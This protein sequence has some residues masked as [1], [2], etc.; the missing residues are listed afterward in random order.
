MTRKKILVPGHPLAPPS[1]L[2]LVSR[3]NLYAKIGGGIHECHWCK[4]KLQWGH[5]SAG[6]PATNCIVVDHL[7]NDVNNDAPENLVPACNGCNISRG[8]SPM[9]DDGSAKFVLVAGV[10]NRA[11]TKTCT[12]CGNEFL[13]PISQLKY[14]KGRF[15]SR[16]CRNKGVARESGVGIQEGELF[17]EVEEANR[18]KRVRAV[19]V[20]CKGC[21]AIMRIEARRARAN[22]NFCGNPCA[23]AY[24]ERMKKQR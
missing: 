9:A 11:E 18:T 24:R 3:V 20:R 14:R 16:A 21:D 23:A 19:E 22:G 7:D 5:G 10:R 4:R 6:R 8:T 1:A 13:I 12:V 2:V 15:C 17:I